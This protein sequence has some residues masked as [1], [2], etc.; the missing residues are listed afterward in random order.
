MISGSESSILVPTAPTADSTAAPAPTLMSTVDTIREESGEVASTTKTST[1]APPPSETQTTPDSAT[2]TT[3]G[4][5]ASA[6]IAVPPPSPPDEAQPGETGTTPP[7]GTVDT[8][9]V[10]DNPNEITGGDENYPI[11]PLTG[12]TDTSGLTYID[13]T[14]NNNGAGD[15]DG[16]V[17]DTNEGADLDGD[18]SGDTG[19]FHMPDLDKKD[20]GFIVAGVSAGLI[21]LGSFIYFFMRSKK[22]KKK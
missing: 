7:S 16:V 11:V 3:L 5:P 8:G 6:T 21:M 20:M 1:V 15:N 9:D 14:D 17:S 2:I 19:G 12:G 4:T 10:V 18:T 13:N 22:G